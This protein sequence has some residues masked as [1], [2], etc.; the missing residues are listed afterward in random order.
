MTKRSLQFTT[1]L[2]ISVLSL[3]FSGCAGTIPLR[4]TDGAA[5]VQLVACKQYRMNLV[6]GPGGRWISSNK[7]ILFDEKR[8]LFRSGSQRSSVA[9]RGD[10]L[11]LADPVTISLMGDPASPES[12]DPSAPDSSS[13]LWVEPGE[14]PGQVVVTTNPSSIPDTGLKALGLARNEIP[15]LSLELWTPG[16]N[17]MVLLLSNGTRY[18][19][20]TKGPV[21]IGG[22]EYRNMRDVKINS[23]SAKRPGPLRTLGPVDATQ[24]S[25]LEYK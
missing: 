2:A 6:K 12:T 23:V 16:R 17:E 8:S 13:T 19:G 5:E 11:V 10:A 7:G 1:S 9:H 18:W 25:H 15:P 14:R 4:T 24:P 3:F 22:R 20:A 21:T